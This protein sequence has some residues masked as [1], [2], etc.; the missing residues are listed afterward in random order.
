MDENVNGVAY[1]HEYLIGIFILSKY[2][3]SPFWSDTQNSLS[4]FD[5]T[6]V[7]VSHLHEKGHKT[8]NWE[9]NNKGIK[10]ITFSSAHET[11]QAAIFDEDDDN[12][13]H[14][15]W[16]DLNIFYFLG[17]PPNKVSWYNKKDD[18]KFPL[19]IFSQKCL[20]KLQP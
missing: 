19:W 2:I 10:E 3:T 16:P 11:N 15:D 7:G 5:K 13:F 6:S 18:L 4:M 20:R 14:A 12:T 9:Q 8:G 17:H 1:N